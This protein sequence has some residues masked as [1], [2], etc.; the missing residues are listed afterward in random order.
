MRPRGP[1]GCT[2]SIRL[3]L[4]HRIMVESETPNTAAACFGL[5]NFASGSGEAFLLI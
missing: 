3:S 1:A 2:V 5:M 4:I